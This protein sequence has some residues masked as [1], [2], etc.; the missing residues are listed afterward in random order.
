M[1]IVLKIRKLKWEKCLFNG[2]NMINSQYLHLK[3]GIKKTSTVNCI[4]C[5]ITLYDL[6]TGCITMHLKLM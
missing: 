3:N 6:F 1:Q 2:N 5:F 4:N